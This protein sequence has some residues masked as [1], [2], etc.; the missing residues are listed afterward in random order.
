MKVDLSLYRNDDYNPG[1][2]RFVRVIWYFVNSLVFNSYIFPV[3]S[4]KSSILRLFGAEIGKG[5]VI[6]PCVNIKYPWRLKIGDYVWIGEKA[7]IDNLADVVIGSN[8][9]LSQGCYLLTGNHD[10]KDPVFSLQV[11]SI[12]LQEGCWVGAR[13]VVCPGANVGAHAVITAGSVLTKNAEP[14]GIYQGN[15]AAHKKQRI[16]R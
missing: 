3:S 6:K 7:W 15:P 16:V 12:N 10:Y 8:A 1:G 9:C 13:S 11:K 4:L 5:V 14:Y 2:G